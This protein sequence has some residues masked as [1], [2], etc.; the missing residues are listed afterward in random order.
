MPRLERKMHENSRGVGG[1]EV[2]GGAAPSPSAIL[3]ERCKVLQR[4]RLK[5]C[6]FWIA[7]SIIH[8]GKDITIASV[9]H[10]GNRTNQINCNSLKWRI[11][12]RHLSQRCLS[13]SSF[14]YC[15][16]TNITRMTISLNISMYTWP[17]EMSHHTIIS[18]LNS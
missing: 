10:R 14:H 8:H 1:G 13:H 18:F 12:Q 9:S 6:C 11:N 7:H 5:C 3:G 2:L 17:K 16:L 4:D 15:S